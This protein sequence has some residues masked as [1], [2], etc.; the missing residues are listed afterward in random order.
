MKKALY[1]L[2]INTFLKRYIIWFFNIFFFI[3][4]RPVI[5]VK[6]V[7]Q[8]LYEIRERNGY[9]YFV[10][11][12]N[13]IFLFTRGFEYRQK[14]LQH[15]Y[16]LN[17]VVVPSSNTNLLFVDIGANI[18]ELAYYSASMNL[19]YVGFEPDPNVYPTLNR[20]LSCFIDKSRSKSF[21]VA[22]GSEN[23][24]IDFF[25][26][27]DK[28]DSSVIEPASGHANKVKVQINRLDSL[29]ISNLGTPFILKIEAEGFEESV[30]NGSLS[31]IQK[32]TYV[33]I[34]CGPENGTKNTMA[35][36]LNIV[37]P[38]GFKVIE[39]NLDRGVVFFKNSNS[40]I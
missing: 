16:L 22:L 10:Q 37:C 40:P 23:D 14:L 21:N 2:L 26:A 32:F 34:D 15:E 19:Y 7:G 38:L 35:E 30:L 8:F 36:C 39:V 31:I 18:G 24:V 25:I 17:H 12:P 1:Q 29:D 5:R 13:R 33:V 28:A 9:V 27:T 4:K 20:N 11:H 6:R 3:F